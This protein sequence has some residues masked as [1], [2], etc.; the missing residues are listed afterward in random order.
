[1]L[2]NDVLIPSSVLFIILLSIVI[3]ST[4]FKFYIKVVL[5]LYLNI[6]IGNWCHIDQK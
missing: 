6:A 4:S 1:M 2:F 5:L 3:Q